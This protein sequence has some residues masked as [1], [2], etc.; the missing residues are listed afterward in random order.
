MSNMFTFLEVLTPAIEL[1][2]NTLFLARSIIGSYSDII[3]PKPSDKYEFF[4]HECDY[5]ASRKFID[6]KF[7]ENDEII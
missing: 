3:L 5:L 2:P 7:D 4:V 6:V 1:Y